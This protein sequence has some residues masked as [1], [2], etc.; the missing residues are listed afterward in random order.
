[1]LGGQVHRLLA[2][3]QGLDDLRLSRQQRRF[4]LHQVLAD[5]THGTKLIPVR[6]RAKPAT[7]QLT[8]Y[9]AAGTYTGTAAALGSAPLFFLRFFCRTVLP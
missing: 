5:H 4:R 9:P 3:G 8:V 7:G 2:G 1:M 6:P